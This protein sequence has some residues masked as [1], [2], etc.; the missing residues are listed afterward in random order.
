[1]RPIADWV[2]LAGVRPI[3]C[4]AFP[5]HSSKAASLC[6]IRVAVRRDAT[7]TE[8]RT[9]IA[10]FQVGEDIAATF[11]PPPGSVGLREAVTDDPPAAAS[12]KAGGGWHRGTQD[13]DS[14]PSGPVVTPRE[15]EEER[16]GAAGPFKTTPHARA[17]RKLCQRS[18]HFRHSTKK[19]EAED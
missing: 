3:D 4:S 7:D 10:P 12:G 9:S 1:M 6:S 5:S 13:S 2:V 8:A 17:A 14:R 11:A 19:E 18:A 15:E 16:E